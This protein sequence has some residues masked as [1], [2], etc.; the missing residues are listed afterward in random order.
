MANI[1]D[2]LIKEIKTKNII[3]GPKVALKNLKNIEKIYLSKDCPEE[4]L[5]N[6]KKF[7]NIIKTN[8]SKKEFG[9]ICKK[10]F[11]ICVI[12]I[13]KQQKLKTKK[14]KK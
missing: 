13:L 11:N 12:S 1:T 14:E 4:I 6:L 8:L 5:R 3:F 2:S 7:D 9:E 10:N